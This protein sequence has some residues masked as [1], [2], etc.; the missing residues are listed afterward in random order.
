MEHALPKHTNKE[1]DGPRD[2]RQ[3]SSM[4]PSTPRKVNPT[5]RSSTYNGNHPRSTPSQKT[6]SSRVPT[7]GRERPMNHQR[8]GHEVSTAHLQGQ[9]RPSQFEYRES[10]IQNG[11]GDIR[12]GGLKHRF[13][14]MFDSPGKRAAL[15]VFVVLIAA[16]V[17]GAVGYQAA[18]VGVIYRG[19]S[20]D[21]IDL[22]G[23]TIEQ[24]TQT[25]N[26]QLAPLLSNQSVILYRTADAMDAV[27]KETSS[28]S[29]ASSSTD[30]VSAAQAIIDV[31]DGTSWSVDAASVGATLDATGMAQ[32]AYSVG[33]SEG[34]FLEA[35][36]A[37]FKGV[38]LSPRITYDSSLFSQLTDSLSGVAGTPM[39]DANISITN[40]VVTV[41]EG[42]DGVAVDIDAFTDA[43]TAAFLGAHRAFILPLKTISQNI[44]A[45]EASD[46]A[47]TVTSALAEPVT[48][49][50]ETK[51]WTL[52]AA[53]MG[54]WIITTVSGTGDGAVLVPSVNP[55]VASSGLT[56]IL[57][58]AV[59]T[60][61][62]DATFSFSSDGTVGI[63]SSQVGV[64]PDLE[65]A[66]ADLQTTLFDHPADNRVIA[67][68]TTEVQPTLTTE[69]AKSYGI[70]TEL[71]SFTTTFNSGA[72]RT[73]NINVAAEYIDGSLISP[74]GTW[75]FWNTVGNAT[76]AR[77]FQSAGALVDG[78]H[79]DAL[80]GGLCQVATTV[81]NAAYD[82]GLPIVERYCHAQY[83]SNYPTGRD[84]A[85]WYDSEDLKFSND[86]GR[87]LYVQA[88]A[89]SYSITI[90]IWG[91]S[92][93]RTVT[94]DTGDWVETAAYTTSTVVDSTKAAGYSAVTTKGVNGSSISVTRTV[95]NADGSVLRT[96]IF[97]SSYSAVA[98]VTTIGPTLTTT[99]TT[100]ATTNTNA[101]TTNSR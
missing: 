88:T 46:V 69:Q 72:A 101:T 11:D 44:D 50:Y 31:S 14:K 22:S 34:G 8:R 23:M 21:G 36:V 20:V 89:T 56:T 90:T 95:Y 82:A 74:D 12:T 81:F 54:S 65:V 27:A 52:D 47:A 96:G 43:L 55:S 32:E 41:I 91:T 78:E 39:V 57:G 75:S 84:A 83:M 92:D 49:T 16:G 71:G 94:T 9:Y 51:T 28:T 98:E 13:L 15:L 5:Y 40:G 2:A 77:G 64:G 35:I 17:I 58:N 100:T 26:E 62:V 61:A 63:S 18:H 29:S 3:V 67:L 73:N 80:G 42:D 85:V 38:D 48:I 66:V 6:S 53:T 68:T 25:L 45:Q 4:K 79:I 76:L 30:A 70:T 19:V 10:T 60:P 24:A 86:T 99:P 97:R 59:G 93:G 7:Y 1:V 87:W 33:R 37:L